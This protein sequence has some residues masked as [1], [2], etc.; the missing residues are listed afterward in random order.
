MLGRLAFVV[1]GLLVAPAVARAFTIESPTPTGAPCHERISTTAVTAVPF[2]A[3]V[4]MPPADDDFRRL[5]AS[6]PFTVP[7]AAR[8]D[9]RVL[10]LLIGVRSPDTDDLA[11]TDLDRLGTLHGD[12]ALQ[13][14]HCLRA[15][16]DDF[17]AGDAT[18]LA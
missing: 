8:A 11:V 10:A 5:A 3:D 15:P 2:P 7:D 9:P 12:P 14:Q 6:V 18:A 4:P 16:G 1:A 17:A 13:M